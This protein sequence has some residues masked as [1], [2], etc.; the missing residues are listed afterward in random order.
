MDKF[1]ELRK[2]QDIDLETD[3]LEAKKTHLPEAER[4]EALQ[5]EIEKLRDELSS[6]E[7][8]FKEEELKQKKME[9]ELDLVSLK[10]EKEEQKLYSGTI[11]NPKELASIQEEIKI[12][13]NKRD[14]Q[15]TVL[16]EQLDVVENLGKEVDE[17]KSMIEKHKKER[18]EVDIE[19]K[20]ITAEIEAQL[21]KLG[22]ERN[23]VIPKIE[24]STLLL[25]EKLK[26]EKQGLAVVE[27][28]DGVCQGCRMELPAEE[29]DKML[30]SDE[31]WQCDNCKRI[32]VR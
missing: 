6:K 10:I 22:S 13:K 19:Y 17:L 16:L 32:I 27:L 1:Q 21:E 4:L 9:G 15:E 23:E 20:R 24:E 30:H 26:E 3:S 31:L 18:D 14:E 8:V 7:E 28:R 25:Y 29:V 5:G 12:L 2:L 11:A